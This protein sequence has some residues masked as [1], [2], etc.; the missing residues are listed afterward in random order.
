[1]QSKIS[2][3]LSE[4]DSQQDNSSRD[5]VLPLHCPASE[6]PHCSLSKACSD[7]TQGFSTPQSVK[8]KLLL[9]PPTSTSVVHLRKKARATPMCVSEVR[10]SPR[11]S[12][13]TRGY[14]AKPC[15]D[16]NCLACAS[17]AP[18]IKKVVVRIYAPSSV[19]QLQTLMMTH[20]QRT[21]FLGRLGL[22]RRRRIHPRR[23]P[24][25]QQPKQKKK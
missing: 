3:I 21:P 15:F 1:M 16:K 25:M 19:F 14:K 4:F 11:I 24:M 23:K 12:A 20:Q 22:P 18:P 13:S 10:R 6:P 5:F 9:A 17:V 2:K 8:P 7:A